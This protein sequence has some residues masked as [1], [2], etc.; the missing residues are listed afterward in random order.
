MSSD[1]QTQPGASTQTDGGNP[2]GI[3]SMSGPSAPSGP[4]P[5]DEALSFEQALDQLQQK[6]KSLEG[7]ELSLES[8]LRSFEDGVTLCRICQQHLAVAEQRVELLMRA[9][10]DGKIETQPFGP[11]RG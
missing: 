3:S 5:P 7:G 9:S 10:A 8:S 4:R 2:S 11:S 6:V 1:S